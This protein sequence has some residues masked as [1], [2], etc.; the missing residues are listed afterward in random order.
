M[1][2]LFIRAIALIA[3]ALIGL[4]GCSSPAG[5]DNV[6]TVSFNAMDGTPTPRD[7]LVANG[8]KAATPN[9]APAKEGYALDGWCTEAACLNKWDF[10]ANV[11][12]ADIT[13]YARWKVNASASEDDQGAS[14]AF[15]NDHAD[16]L[17]KTSETAG[18]GDEEAVDAAL[19]AYSNLE[20]VVQALLLEEYQ[21]LS[22]LKT[23]IAALRTY[24]ITFDSQGG[25]P[26][27]AITEAAGTAV[28]LPSVPEKGGHVFEGW[29][30]DASGGT[31]YTWPHTLN[32]DVT[33][34]ARWQDTPPLPSLTGTVGISG[35]AKAGEVLTANTGSLGGTGAI[36]YQWERGDSANGAFADIAGAIDATYTLTAAD[37]GKY[38]RVTVSRAGYDGAKSSAAS[39][40]V[41]AADLPALTGSVSITETPKVGL[42]LTAN[43]GGLGGTGAISYQWERSDTAAGGFTPIAGATGASY[44]LVTADLGQY[45]RVT[46]SR[47]G[48]SGTTSS[49]TLKVPGV[50]GAFTVTTWIAN[51]GTLLSDAPEDFIVIS[52]SAQ[53]TLTMT[54]AAGL[55]NI[56]W[57]LNGT[58]LTALRGA[59]AIAIGAASYIPGFYNLSMY[60]EKT[61]GI[62]YQINIT[63]VVDN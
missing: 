58:E 47:A 1:K 30:S 6:Y 14:D 33:M 10:A 45:V 35:T 5:D 43:T 23:A 28:P 41:A 32:A 57:S 13:L 31:L 19:A 8:Q 53:E 4:T 60:A 22:G 17:A 7:Q 42:A 63:F 46:A 51:D 20:P 38:V 15:R 2:K 29:Y 36:S 18:L 3:V 61:G 49:N 11:V 50:D 52:K 44:T 34:Y 59:P 48:Y 54:A 26:V 56:K 24:V 21:R 27:Q 9:P 55:G 62:P 16:I 25:T 12:T 40:P 39:G 37:H